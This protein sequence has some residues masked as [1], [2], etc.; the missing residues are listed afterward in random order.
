MRKLPAPGRSDASAPGDP[1]IAR[2]PLVL[3]LPPLDPLVRLFLNLP[4]RCLPMFTDEGFRC[5][6]RVA[7]TPILTRRNPFLV[8]KNLPGSGSQRS[9]QFI[10]SGAYP[11]K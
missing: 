1:L 3:P 9:L 7:T 11:R 10:G 5:D 8:A 4:E 2:V 6:I